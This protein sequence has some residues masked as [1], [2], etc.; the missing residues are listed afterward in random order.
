MRGRQECFAPD[1]LILTRR[2]LAVHGDEWEIEC[3]VRQLMED[4]NEAA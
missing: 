4:C 3:E 1:G 2:F